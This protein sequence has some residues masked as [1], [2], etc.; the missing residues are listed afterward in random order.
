[1]VRFG[2]IQQEFVYP[3][4]VGI[5]GKPGVKQ[6]RVVIGNLLLAQIAGSP[7][8]FCQPRKRLPGA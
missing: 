2:V 7:T 3:V 4:S 5:A 8:E 1:M 6:A